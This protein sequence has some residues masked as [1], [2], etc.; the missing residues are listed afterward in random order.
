MFGNG[1]FIRKPIRTIRFPDKYNFR[2]QDQSFDLKLLLEI[3]LQL[4]VE[5][6]F[7]FELLLEVELLIEVELLKSHYY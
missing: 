1:V 4:E 6:L 2:F 3:E 7:D 5:L